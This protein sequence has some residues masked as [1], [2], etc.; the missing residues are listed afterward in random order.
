MTTTIDP[1]V[2]H[3]PTGSARPRRRASTWR[4]AT[5]LARR[6]VRRRPGRTLLV[7]LLVAIPV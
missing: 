6:E 4:F 3:A 2:T 7:M 5:R 1:R